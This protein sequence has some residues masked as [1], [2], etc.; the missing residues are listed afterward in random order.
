M[1]FSKGFDTAGY[2]VGE[3]THS[4]RMGGDGVSWETRDIRPS[5]QLGLADNMT[6][7][8]QGCDW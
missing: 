6:A 1:I 4:G 2:L 3:G 8:D 5:T 7:G